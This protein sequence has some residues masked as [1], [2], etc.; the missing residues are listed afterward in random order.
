MMEYKFGTWY[1]IEELKE[2]GEDVLFLGDGTIEIGFLHKNS[3]GY[4]SHRSRDF[5]LKQT[6][7]TKWMPLPPRPGEE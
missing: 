4:I 2:F 1:P 3:L 6:Y 5:S 7:P